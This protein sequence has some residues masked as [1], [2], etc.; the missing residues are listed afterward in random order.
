MQEASFACR[1]KRMLWPEPGPRLSRAR[2]KWS[3]WQEGWEEP[4]KIIQQCCTAKVSGAT[5]SSAI[6]ETKTVLETPKLESS[7]WQLLC[8]LDC[9]Y[10]KHQDSCFLVNSSSSFSTAPSL[11]WGPCKISLPC[12]MVH[13]LSWFGHVTKLSHTFIGNRAKIRTSTRLF[14]F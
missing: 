5:A 13:P 11:L 14:R 8:M 4:P 10:C 12:L 9:I 7:K 6:R 1:P 2:Q 3:S